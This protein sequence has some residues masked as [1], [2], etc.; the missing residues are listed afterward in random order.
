MVISP[1]SKPNIAQASTYQT[2]HDQG[3]SLFSAGRYEEALAYF[4][5]A[6]ALMPDQANLWYRQGDALANLTRY[7]E[8][9]LSLNRALALK[10]DYQQAWA[11][12]GAVLI[13]LERYSEALENCNHALQLQ[14]SDA[15]TWMMR[16][17]ALYYLKQYKQAYASYDKALGIERKP[18]S[19]R[20]IELALSPVK[21]N[22]IQSA[23]THISRQ[24]TRRKRVMLR[25]SRKHFR[26]DGWT[27]S[28]G[29]STLLVAAIALV[30]LISLLQGVAFTANNEVHSTGIPWIQDQR[31]CQESGR[32][33]ENSIC[34]DQQHDPNF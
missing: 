34:W 2:L 14:P 19:K 4:N 24:T 21:Q 28:M 33:W 15:E 7:P 9:L 11:L 22:K 8:A 18:L 26:L 27:I 23:F 20:L 5:Q 3:C 17:A 13:Y 25:K 30:A 29:L 16:G 32:S 10:P 12:R 1:F 31:T 6:V